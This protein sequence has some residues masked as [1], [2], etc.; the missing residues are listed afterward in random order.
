MK[1]RIQISDDALDS[2]DFSKEDY[3][4]D[5]LK[6]KFEKDLMDKVFYLR[7]FLLFFVLMHI[8][9]IMRRITHLLEQKH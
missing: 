1:I 8:A 3:Y 6:E 9:K 4:Q 5:C 2:P 7:L